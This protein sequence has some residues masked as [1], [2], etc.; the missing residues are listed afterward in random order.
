MHRKNLRVEISPEAS[1]K[2]E[3]LRAPNLKDGLRPSF[4]FGAFQAQDSKDASGHP[5]TLGPL[6]PQI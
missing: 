2:F 6:K 3:A 1:F 4:N 5:S